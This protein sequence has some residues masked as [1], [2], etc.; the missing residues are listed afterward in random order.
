MADIGDL[1]WQGGAPISA[2]WAGPKLL[3]PLF[4]E[5]A[6]DWRQRYSEHRLRNSYGRTGIGTQSPKIVSSL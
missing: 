1:G 2:G 6:E 5:I 4:D 3:G